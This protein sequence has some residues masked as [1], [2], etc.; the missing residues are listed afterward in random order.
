[1][2]NDGVFPTDTQFQILGGDVS[3]TS[4]TPTAAN[5][6]DLMVVSDPALGLGALALNSSRQEVVF[7]EGNLPNLDELLQGMGA[8]REVHVL[9]PEQDGLAQMAQILAGRSG[10][11]AIHLL[12]HGKAGAVDLGSLLLDKTQLALHQSELQQ[13]GQSLSPDADFLIYGCNVGAGEAGRELV[14]D[15]AIATGADVAASNDLTGAAALGGDWDLEVKLGNIETA[16]V[17]DSRLAGLYASVLDIASATVGFDYN[18][19]NLI[20][21]GSHKD[22]SVD[23][24]YRIN[25]DSNYDLHANG[26]T[27]PVY[28]YN[29]GPGVNYFLVDANDS[30]TTGAGETSVT[31]SFAAGN[32]FTANAVDIMNYGTKSQ[33][34]VFQGYDASNNKVGTATNLV[35]STKAATVNTATFA[36]FTDITY[37]KMTALSGNI[38]YVAVDT[39]ALTNIKGLVVA[40]T[41]TVASA[42]MS[43]DTGVSSSDFITN[44]S[45]QRI[46][47]TLSSKLATGEYVEVSFD[48]GTTWSNATN[49]TVD[50]SDWYT[51]TTLSGSNTFQVRVSNSGGSATAYSHTYQLDTTAPATPSTPDLTAGT[52]I[53]TSSTD[54]ITDA[55]TPTFIG[56]GEI[57]SVVYIYDTDGTTEIGH[58]TVNGS[59][60]WSITGSGALSGGVHTITAK[61]GDTAGNM[62]SATSALTVTVV[63]TSP[64]VSS[65][66]YDERSGVLT[67][68]GTGFVA[69]AS[70]KDIDASLFTFKGQG[71]SYTLTD[72]A[73]V[74]ISSS[75][76]FQIAVS[77][78]D[79]AAL[80]QILTKNGTSS[81][82]GKTYSVST[83]EGWD[84]GVA[85]TQDSA[86][87]G[88]GMTVSGIASITQASYVVSGASAG[89][90]TFV[91][92]GL[93]TVNDTVDPTKLTLELIDSGTTKASYTLT[94]P[95]SAGAV[96][97]TG[98]TGFTIQLNAA[99][100]L[101]ID[102]LMNQDGTS[103]LNGYSYHIAAAAGWNTSFAYSPDNYAGTP[104]VINPGSASG[105]VVPTIS[106]ATYNTSTHVL[107]ATGQNMVALQGANDVTIPKLTLTGLGGVDYTLTSGDVDVT[108]ATSFSVT[109]NSTDIAAFSALLDKD[110]TKASDGKTY[111]LS[112]AIYW[113]TEVTTV[114]DTTNALTVVTPPPVISEVI[115][116]SG[117]K[118]YKVGDIVT[119]KVSFDQAVVVDD[120]N[121]TPRI[122]LETGTNDE[123]AAY[124]SGSGSQDLEFAYTVQAGDSSADLQYFDTASFDLNS[125][126]I[127][128]VA[129]G[130][131]A[132]LT[133]PG[134]SSGHS[135]AETSAVVIDGIAP[136]A[137]STPDLDAGS[138]T[139]SS[140]SDDITSDTTPTLSGTAEANATVTLYD[141]DGTTVLGTA[142]A[143][144]SGNW[145]ITSSTLSEGGHTLT[146][147]ATDTAGN[148]SS[149]S[150][151]LSVTIDTTAP[152]APSAPDLTA[153][154]DSGVSSNDNI[155]NKT[156]L[157][158]IG[159]GTI[160]STVTLYDTDGT[161]V[162]G[163]GTVNGA[164][165][166]SITSSKLG[167]GDHTIGA[168]VSD[169]AGNQSALSSTLSVTIDTAAP[170]A[171]SAPNLD[172]GS[173]T[174]S[175]NSDDL[176]SATTPTFT[177]TAEA[178]STVTLYDTD[179]STVLGTATA[180]GSGNWS[181]TSSTLA[182]GSHTLTTKAVDTAGN[183]SVASGELTVTLD[184]TAPSSPGTPDL[185]SG[186]DT[187]SSSTDKLTNATT[188][189]VTGT[190]EANSTVTLYDTDG[191]TVLGTATA[192]GK[193]NWSITS[194]TLSEGSHTLTTKATDA[195]GNTSAA[196][197][198]L[199]VTVDTTP[200]ST[201]AAPT[202]SASSDSGV[203]SSDGITNLTTLDFSGSTEAFAAVKLF[204]TDGK[205]VIGTTTA[206]ALGKWSVTS[207]SL[208]AGTHS[209]TLEVTD[210]AG[211][212]SA[213]SPATTVEIDNTAPAL[214]SAIKLS[215]TALK[216]GDTSTVTFTFTEAVSD[217]TT[218]DVT[219]ANGTLSKLSSS[220]GGT[221]W[222][223]TLT[224]TADIE[225]ATNILTLDNTG[226]AD[227]AG[228][229]GTGT[230]N[231]P[232]YKIDTLRPSLASAITISDTALKIGDTATATFTFTEAVSGFTTA[233]VTVPHGTLSNLSSS[234]GGTTWTAT[235]TP[236][237]STTAA[238]NVLTLDY[239]GISDAAGNAGSGTVDSPNYAV[240]TQ[241]PTATISLSDT[242]LK[243][244][245]TSTVTFTFTEAVSGFTTADLLADNGKISDLSS[246]DGG[247]TWTA[248]L[249]PDASIS[250]A[251]NVITL[252]YTGVTDTAGN[253]G[254]GTLDSANYAIDTVRPT[255][256]SDITI[257]DTALKIG[258]T[259]TV[260]F[261]FTEAVSDFTV[262]DV[263]VA[264][265]SL[266]KLSS[267]DGGTT[268]TATLT[269][270]DNVADTA[271]IL[272]L[273]YTGITDAAGNA[274][275]GTVD[276][277]NYAIDTQR[278]TLASA[279]GISDTALK[280]GDTATVTFTFMD[281]VSGFTTADVTVSHGTLS[282]LSSSDG[283]TTWTATLTPAA[284]TTAATNVLTLDYTGVTNA[285]G[286]AGTGTV[287]S[288]N[289]AI[290]TVRPS[291]ASTIA[292]SDTALK[293]GD[294][295]T[296]T[297]AFTEAVTGFTAADVTVANG[298]LSK[299]SS[300][301]GGTTWTAT[302]TPTSSITA[303]TNVLTLNNSGITDLAGNAGSGTSNSPNYAIDTVRPSLASSITISDTALK[304]GDT[305]TVTFAFTE[306]VTG[307][308]T[309][310]V[311]VANGSL[312]K[313]SSSD[314][315]L[316]WTATLTPAAGAT[317]AS[318]VLTLDYTG[319]AD[320]AGNAGTGTAD[321]ASYAVD[322]VRPSLA[323]SIAISDTALKIGDT[324]T[325][326]FAF[327]EAVTG[328]TTAD[329]TVANGSLSNLSSNDGGLTWTATLTPTAGTTAATNALTLDYTGI[330]DAAGNT[331][332]GS[333][334]SANYAVDTQRPTATIALSDTALKVGDTATVT[335]TFSEAVTGFSNADLSIANGTLSAVGSSDGGITWTAIYTPTANVT[336][337]SNLITLNNA[338]ITDVA[339][340][341]GTGSTDSAPYAIDTQRPTATIALSDSALKIGDTATVTVTF[342]E[343]VT[344]FSNA[345]LS[346][347]NGTLSAVG[348]SDGG[349]TWT[350]IYT[351]TANVTDASNAITLNNAGVADAAGNAGSGSTDSAPYAVDT[352]RPTAT[353]ALSD[354]AL[355]VGDTATVTV[356]F[357][358]AVTGFTNADLSVANGTLSAVGSNDGGTTW[359]ATYTPTANLTDASNVITLNNAGVADAAGNAGT[360]STD[361]APYAIDTQRPTA[362]IAL[363]DSAL[364]IGDT[365]TVTVTFSEAVTGFSNADLSVANGT[366]SAVSSNDGGT[367]W[368]AIYTP[369]A[370]VESTANL[371]T[372]DNAGI[373]DVAGNAGTG[374]T[375]SAPYA[376][377]T[378]RP[379]AT[380][381][382]SD[383][384]LKIGDTATVTVTFSEAVS[385]F[386]NADLSVA[387][388]T[389][390][391]VS[392]S[393]GGLTWTATYTPTAGVTDT[394]NLITLDNTGVADAAGNT[395][396]G[397]A[398]TLNYAVDTLAPAA[399]D[400]HVVAADDII[401]AQEVGTTLTGS[402]EAGATVALSL[403]GNTRTATVDGTSW[404]YTLVAADIAAMGEGVK[405]IGATQTDAAG[406]VGNTATRTITVA[407]LAPNAPSAPDLTPA[408]DTGTSSSDNLT[409][410]TT[411]TFVGTA[412][413]G[414]AVALY[415]TDGTTLLG[416]T[417][418]DDS[419][420]WSITAS[421]LDNGV[422]TLT[423]KA[424]DT[425]GNV[426]LASPSLSVTID[427]ADD[428]DN[429]PSS[430]EQLVPVLEAGGVTGDGNGDGVADGL[431]ANV[432]SVPFLNT[433]TAQSHPGDAPPVFVTLV[434]DS[435]NGKTDT[436]QAT[437]TVLKAVQQLDAPADKPAD[438]AMPLG[439]I[440]F[441]AELATV[442]G[443]EHFSLYVDGSIP[444]N[445]YWKQDAAG[446]WVNLASAPYGGQ[447][448]TEGG[449]TRLD[450]QI[451]D[452]S[453]FDSDGVKNGVI[454]DPGAPGYRATT[455]SSD[456][457]NDQF[458]DALEA[459]NGLTVGTKDNDVFGSTK[460]FVMQLYR[461]TLFREAESGGL[462]YWMDQIG[463]GT[464]TRDE[465][466]QRFLESPEFQDGAGGLARLYLGAF[467]RLPDK[468][469]MDYWMA[470]RLSDHSLATIGADFA[471]SAEF[472]GLYDGLDNAGFLSQLYQHVLDRAPDTAGQTYWQDRLT[473]GSSRSDVL[474][475]IT[476]S[477]EARAATDQAV[478]VTLDYVGLLGRTP[479]PAGFDYWMGKLDDGMPVTEVIGLFTQTTEYHDRFLP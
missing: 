135:L 282:N 92:S 34:L 463:S 160:G 218:A 210:V 344:G 356:T 285:A 255:L 412:Q 124:V 242:A 390:S 458:P 187:G 128:S 261:T 336:D 231:S 337:A 479:E 13:I 477:A 315:G 395:G 64:V 334:D 229:A 6:D 136:A 265:G 10:I 190:A 138:D 347:A 329:V 9:D 271:N 402:N 146:T 290:D 31:F 327:T 116:T 120:T 273:D 85:G 12:S 371:I 8:G 447:V 349:I 474:L 227:L 82:N 423:A 442:G 161:T 357:S 331:G 50:S 122:L 318:N 104:A 355:K 372:L 189:T 193:G 18:S 115:Q 377:D 388:G 440:G 100:Q 252:D 178:N 348:S 394:S 466:A 211:N 243:I 249:T 300:S 188:P 77:A 194:S 266:S 247:I 215:D 295:A 269:P 408:S 43:A 108:S 163:T 333:V 175:S 284:G 472:K 324:A 142:T 376:I 283:G 250:S 99:D 68:T 80:Q 96:T 207:S 399:P 180:D 306:A 373:T 434:S 277:P 421:A 94:T 299:L 69:L 129:N 223:A 87:S 184:T 451:T 294:T 405:T 316:T 428:G 30:A 453:E 67:V 326:T 156:T 214:A 3:T 384:A 292:I 448:V 107:T 153:G 139:G 276:S 270:T 298:S 171:P 41:T 459:A 335:V 455:S 60:K 379:T 113:N 212:V 362:T 370:G 127:V 365:A 17:V 272:T 258:D 11:D 86:F 195:G 457:D 170:A 84:T 305:A 114:A 403:G 62:S 330:T 151:G 167:D 382:L 452:G 475:E 125:G 103:N 63:D 363:S 311:T 177:G 164:G 186:S 420:H 97:V 257:S 44:T 228:N 424:L 291:L 469:G 147:K 248:T 251:T 476:Q 323:S 25:G 391:A 81:F 343:A 201:P 90:M 450:F 49:Y 65:I 19:A 225:D 91:G 131:A 253:A 361:S 109:L 367:T 425:V 89:L 144:G 303:A 233:D 137:P 430:T 354:T 165:K 204:D 301:D 296:V 353:I 375:D 417:V 2:M 359:T 360:G 145:S 432:T 121:G 346:V 22:A 286:N 196:S 254:T 159:T 152:G 29:N 154:T 23:V 259:A 169:A 338:G 182:E 98:T 5:L 256:A 345:D 320:A 36:G 422:H 431:Q 224:P 260:T 237:A 350:A 1:M 400:I 222:T 112:A 26:A 380:I 368:T 413:A 351:P 158:F 140:N 236:S 317:A 328:F 267:S 407:T 24:V 366:L 414:M 332:S 446:D 264:N 205:T 133:L 308:T 56:T 397:T 262:A 404:S 461:D 200:P 313:L 78:T 468:A 470:E 281:A 427:T 268:W 148:V 289:Y 409:S 52:D 38:H 174:G 307:F 74:E 110:G 401:N 416:S 387:N 27:Q 232:N 438:L 464:L 393:D 46:S 302:L 234:D 28:H 42:S 106:S 278:P 101:F 471:G 419:G 51:D 21:T 14:N 102:G 245:D 59:G 339:G 246:S 396:A 88:T 352:Q 203:S 61:A 197:S 293:I 418:A 54:N 39:I 57:G 411:P 79:Q 217:F 297:F 192:D 467:G 40:P 33:T 383:T 364:K 55:T 32:M 198:A 478:G 465:V 70:G 150:A 445:G 185:A 20:S 172:A 230:S 216:V 473:S 386:S 309:A 274:G 45:A 181:I 310:D 410:S 4:P 66:A 385:G 392:S 149:A 325:V 162:V 314:G 143:D 435:I 208:S 221:T 168:K 132:D 47:G 53:G 460:F 179:G 288:G 280:I 263:T 72:T 220:D 119:F 111:N 275:S 322:T 437:P 83:A 209:V 240:D 381:A 389:L 433:D 213:A 456:S 443:T 75:T 130:S 415:D 449:K 398:S 15:L 173:D 235:L 312:S 378:Q 319:I 105:V 226:I 369:T 441:Q 155:T 439:L 406:N 176:T 123:Y 444:I 358:E 341:A 238:T 183:T 58:S 117:D 287:K 76:S 340:N 134:T 462:N 374:S 429:V 239:T 126:A 244:G 93:D 199:S 304:I 16:V 321:S 141:T 35:L 157:T 279:I 241:R 37:L 206:D 426:S 191:T 219:V 436:T 95:Y 342:S 202:L 118:S 454:S 73:D 7:V 48:N 71:G 166:W